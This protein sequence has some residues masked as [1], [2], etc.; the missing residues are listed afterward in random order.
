MSLYSAFYASLSGLSSNANALGVIGNNL[1]NLN[2]VGY[3]ASNASF[4]DLFSTALTG[5]TTGGNG[6]P[7]QIGLGTTLAAV[8]QDFSQGSPS[9]SGTVTNMAL[10]GNGFFTLK[11]TSGEALY[12]RAGNFSVNT[13]GYLTDPNGNSVMGW[14]AVNG[15]VNPSGTTQPVFLN[16]GATSPPSP[17]TTISNTTNL[18]SAATAGTTFTAP[19]AVYDSLGATHNIEITY[20]AT[21][22]PGTWTTSVSTDDPTVPTVTGYPATIVFNSNGVLTT[23]AS[24]VNPTL[25]AI[26]WSNGATSPALKVNIWSGTP[27]ASGLT[28]YAEASGTSGTTEDGYASGTVSSLAVDSAGNIVGT[29]TNGQT[30]TLAQV[31]VATF[32]NNNGLSMSGNNTWSTTLS[33]GAANI[34][35]ANSGGRGAILGANLEGSNVDVATEFTKLIINQNGYQ[36]NS[37]VITTADTLLQT[38]I[39]MIQ[40]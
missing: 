19:I 23:P 34:G 3:K 36:A 8:S 22:T 5:G 13:N 37:R 26:N 6:D 17:T 15:K 40:G 2:T 27:A 12:T 29:F 11:S 7:E 14:N 38:V 33:S 20:T 28:G 10:Q 1:A 31:A 39:S 24:G 4:Q 35:Q 30:L 9:A 32:S 18:N 16:P 21:A 25:G